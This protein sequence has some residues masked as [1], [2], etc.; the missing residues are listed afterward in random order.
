VLSR[1][2]Q[3]VDAHRL[4][5]FDALQLAAAIELDDADLVLATWD[6][7]LAKVARDEGLATAP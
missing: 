7:E 4:R 3:V 2:A 6:T 1:A 5:A